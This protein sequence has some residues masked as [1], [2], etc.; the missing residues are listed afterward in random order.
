[1]TGVTKRSVCRLLL[2]ALLFTQGALAAYACPAS[3]DAPDQKLAA[4]MPADCDQKGPKSGMD[5]DTPNLCLAHC[6]SGQQ[7]NDHPYTPTVQAVMINVLTI[8]LPDLKAQAASGRTAI[9][10]RVPVAASTPHT[11]LH[12]CFR[13]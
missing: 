1:M 4:A 2:G 10:E 13:I 7:S 3:F 6:Q 12:C 5:A 11:I 9:V 8:E